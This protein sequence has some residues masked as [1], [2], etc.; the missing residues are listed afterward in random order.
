[1]NSMFDF[2]RFSFGLAAGIFV[3]VLKLFADFSKLGADTSSK[4][5]GKTANIF[6]QIANYEQGSGLSEKD[7]LEY[8]KKNKKHS[9]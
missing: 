6:S 8:E 1:M 7:R 5:I 2:L 9:A 3:F 4:T